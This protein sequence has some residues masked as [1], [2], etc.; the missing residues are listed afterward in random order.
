MIL[1]V[2]VAAGVVV[3][4]VAVLVFG[5]SSSPSILYISVLLFVLF[6]FFL[7]EPQYR[8]KHT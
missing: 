3:A 8:S 5:P 7:S 2:V 4:A 6:S 1:A